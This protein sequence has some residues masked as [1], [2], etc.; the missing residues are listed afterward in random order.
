MLYSAEEV[1]CAQ[2][3]LLVIFRIAAIRDPLS[4]SVRQQQLIQNN[5]HFPYIRQ[6]IA[7]AF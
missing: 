1:R 4:S 2:S 6:S 5:T 7:L 3:Q